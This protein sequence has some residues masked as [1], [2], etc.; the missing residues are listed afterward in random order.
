M[1][2]NAQNIVRHSKHV[3]NLSMEFLQ[4]DNVEDL[5]R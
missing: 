4:S 3:E 1:I 2:K 5:A